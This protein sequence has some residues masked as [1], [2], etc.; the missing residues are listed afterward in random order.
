MLYRALTQQAKKHPEKI[1]VA[2]EQKTL[3]F[4]QLLNEVDRVASSLH[5]FNLKAGDPI[6]L[7]VPP[8]PD[9]YV[10]FYAAC[11][12]GLTLIPVLPAGKLSRAISDVQPILAAG[13]KSFLKEISAGC[14]SL[15]CFVEWD[16]SAGFNLPE[17]RNKRFRGNRLIRQERILGILTSGTTGEPT[18]HFTEAETLL[19]HGEVRAKVIGITAD[20]V[21]L[22]TRPFNNMSSI[23]APVILP[24]ITGCKVVVRESFRRFEAAEVI[25]R[26]RVTV[27][28]GVP[29]IF[30]MLASIPASHPAEFSSLR[31]C[32]SGGAPLP[33]YVFDKFYKRFGVRIRQRYGGT[34]FFPAFNFD[35]RGLPGTVGQVSGP[36]PM[37]IIDEH[38]KEAAIGE[39]GE[40][41][42]NYA[43]LRD[44]FWRACLKTNP[45]L[46][47]KYIHTG[48]LGR[49]D[50]DGNL[51]I[52][53]RKSPFI[54]VGGNRV[55]PAEVECVLRSHPQVKESMVVAY[56]PGRQ[57]ESIHAI[58]VP[59]G[60]LTPADLLMHCARNLD[61][62]K[63][64]RRIDFRSRLPRNAQGKVIRYQVPHFPSAAREIRK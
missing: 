11:A 48:D 12:L 41:V 30:E 49:V 53:G 27:I 63:C 25:H 24:I 40:I 18:L 21:L 38:G 55:A 4:V 26:E 52:V 46:R 54:K 23:D 6:I 51:Y 13:D 8:S 15:R 29:I 34:Q 37:T 7:G 33:R 14:P 35:T 39:M 36:F 16:K 45:D 32:V 58:V 22:S 20:D 47:G 59:S 60:R 61:A 44:P 31:L 2:G 50:A 42:L 28:Y 10:F 56:H 9:F 3:S 1:A 62:Y 17:R 43:K 19:R 64:P 57:D 5:Q